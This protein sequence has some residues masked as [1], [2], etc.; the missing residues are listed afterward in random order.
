[1]TMNPKSAITFAAA[2]AASVILVRPALGQISIAEAPAV[3]R[4]PYTCAAKFPGSFW[5]LGSGACWQCPATHPHRTIFIPITVWN[6]CE[7]SAQTVFRKPTGPRNATGLIG[8]D[9]TSGWFLHWDRKC[10]SCGSGYVRTADPNIASS[11]ACMRVIPPA[12]T[13]ATRQGV[14]GCPDGAFR[15]GLTASC[16]SCP[17]DHFRNA[18][19]A[20]DLTKVNACSRI[21]NDLREATR[22][23][24]EQQ[25][26]DHPATR[27][28]LARAAAPAAGPAAPPDRVGG[29]RYPEDSVRQA[30]MEVMLEAE[31]ERESGFVVVSWMKTAG[32]SLLVGYT[33]AEGYAMTKV[34]TTYACRKASS[35]AFTA[36]VSAGVGASEEI[37]L[38]QSPLDSGRSETNG[39]QVAVALGLTVSRGWHW[40]GAGK[41]TL[42]TSVTH[43][44]A[45]SATVVA[46]VSAE[47]V[48]TWEET[49]EVVACNQMTWGRPPAS[50]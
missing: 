23:K 28:N 44:A 21:S 10:Y 37:G 26:N 8:T 22:A 7:R 4:G 1:M 25:K 49:G 48:H 34:D 46:D 38:S 41:L 2:L 17:P 36:G 39:W 6:A 43:V 18:V 11:R 47:Y 32:G 9:C 16:Y 5:D 29:G 13:K 35:D 19:I 50:T 3:Y 31:L 42:A 45:P 24:Y 20:D 27:A 33:R 12:W 15:N 30:Q 14:E 40:D